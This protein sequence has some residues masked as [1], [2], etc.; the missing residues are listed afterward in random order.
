MSREL[1]LTLASCVALAVGAFAA[2]L[3][4]RL[5]AGKGV[6]P[7]PAAT[8]WVREVGVLLVATGVTVFLVRSQ[9]DS[10]ALR[11]ILIGSCVTQVGLLG[12]EPVAYARGVIT[13]LSGIVPNTV[14]HVVLAAGFAYYA[15]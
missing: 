8:V 6:A 11:A 12:I 1:F 10:A 7:G 15:C 13:K 9:P 2:V 3:P 5:L 4:R 14:L